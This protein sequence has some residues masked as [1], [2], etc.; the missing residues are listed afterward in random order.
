MRAAAIAAATLGA[1]LLAAPASAHI[2]HPGAIDLFNGVSGAY[3]L[4]VAATPYVGSLEVTVVVA[5]DGGQ[6]VESAVRVTLSARA[7]DGSEAVGPARA[8]ANDL[9]RPND[10]WAAL[11]PRQAGAWVVV[12]EVDSTL[13][14]TRLELPLTLRERGGG[15]P[16]A[17][18]VAITVVAAPLALSA[19]LARRRRRAHVRRKDAR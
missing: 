2:D 16:W 8:F 12:V 10:Y 4:R 14:E 7:D 9:S 1:A 6:G 15:F 11:A 5:D 19:V 13:G 17:A 18:A 3:A